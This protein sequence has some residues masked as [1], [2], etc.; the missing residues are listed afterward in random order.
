[1][2]LGVLSEVDQLYVTPVFGVAFAV[3]TFV[4]FVGEQPMPTDDEELI[5][6]SGGIVVPTTTTDKLA[7]VHPVE[8]SVTETL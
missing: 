2:I 5:L 1:M 8:G 3:S 7:E 6:S 4:L